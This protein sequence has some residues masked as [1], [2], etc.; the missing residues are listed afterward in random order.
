[1]VSDKR[2]SCLELNLIATER[3][4]KMNGVCI[5]GRLTKDPEVKYTDNQLAVCHFSV[6]I[7]RGKDKDGNDRGADFPNCIA[8]GKA[9]ENIGKFFSK[10]R[11]I[12]L[13]GRLQTGSYENKEG[14]KVYTT[15]V[16]VDRFDFCDSNNGSQGN[17]FTRPE[18]TVNNSDI[19]DG[20]EVIEDDDIPL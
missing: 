1:M 6:A 5:I 12:G 10:G 7:N 14:N 19:P 11:L 3:Q 2:K 17:G 13:N 16:I 20:F 8:F 15:D 4:K 9:A 18:G